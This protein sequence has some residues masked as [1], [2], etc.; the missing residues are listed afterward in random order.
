LFLEKKW[1]MEIMYALLAAVRRVA[2]KD[3]V[4]CQFSVLQS[5]NSSCSTSAM[6][7]KMLVRS[8]QSQSRY[9]MLKLHSVLSY[10]R[11]WQSLGREFTGDWSVY[12]YR[13]ISQK[14]RSSWTDVYQTFSKYRTVCGLYNIILK[15]RRLAQETLLW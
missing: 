3:V 15:L 2:M 14:H 11:R 13:T 12:P 8:R 6:R 7:M 1:N 4:S 10:P 9:V 5:S